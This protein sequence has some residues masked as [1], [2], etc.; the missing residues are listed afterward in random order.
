MPRDIVSYINSNDINFIVKKSLNK[1][2]RE[3]P[4]DPLA[5]I[6]GLLIESATKSYP[7]FEKFVAKGAYLMDSHAY[8]TVQIDVYLTF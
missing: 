6:A 7:V 3:K 2:L 8:E 1:V 5:T 4:A